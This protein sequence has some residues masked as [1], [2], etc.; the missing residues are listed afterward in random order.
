MKLLQY[1]SVTGS[2][3]RHPSSRTNRFETAT[4]LKL[5]MLYDRLYYMMLTIIMTMS[6]TCNTAVMT[7]SFKIA[8]WVYSEK[9]ITHINTLREKNAAVTAG[10]TCFKSFK[11]VNNYN[12][13]PNLNVH[14]TGYISLK[15]RVN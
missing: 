11:R 2:S 13:P 6:L 7:R 12:G 15:L 10:V 14:V 3:S 9:H 1:V 5:T 4:A 8:F